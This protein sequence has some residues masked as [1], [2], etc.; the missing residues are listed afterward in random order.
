MTATVNKRLGGKNG[1]KTVCRDG[2][3][4]GIQKCAGLAYRPGHVPKCN[5]G[6]RIISSIIM[7]HSSKPIVSSCLQKCIR[8]SHWEIN[9]WCIGAERFEKDN[10]GAMIAA[11]DIRCLLFIKCKHS[12][13]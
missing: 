4:P 1:N 8:A 11:G 3:C 13:V 2:N 9:P 10:I 12:Y 7:H 6:T 5:L